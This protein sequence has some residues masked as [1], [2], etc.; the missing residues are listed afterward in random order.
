MDIIYKKSSLF[1]APKGS[2]LVQAVNSKGVWG[3][4]IAKEFKKHFPESFKFYKELCKEEGPNLVGTVIECPKEKDYQVCNLV[5]SEGYGKFKDPK[6]MILFN[7][8]TAVK[9]LLEYNPNSDINSNKFNS[10][11]FNVPWH[12]TEKIILDIMKETGYS[13][14]W[15]VWEL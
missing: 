6:E 10:G 11:L 3:A 4:G 2:I 7:T 1:D 13:K 15:T 5:I 14:E 12:E 8:R 9:F